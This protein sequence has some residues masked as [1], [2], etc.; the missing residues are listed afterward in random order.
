MD[1]NQDAGAPGAPTVRRA[2][3][4]LVAAAIIALGGWL[5][6]QERGFDRETARI[7]EVLELE[8][9]M[10]VADV[11]AGDG[12]FSIFLAE[13]VG[14]SGRVFSTEINDELVDGVREAVGG[15]DLD[16]VTVIL[17]ELDGTN[18]PDAC[19]DRILLRRVYH[20]FLEADPMDQ[21]MFA[22][23]EPGGLIAVIDF[24]PRDDIAQP[25]GTPAERGGHGTPIDQLIDE[26]T[27]N[28]FELDRQVDGWPGSERDYCVVFRKPVR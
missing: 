11:G 9:G 13:R 6:W 17:G 16:N 3:A 25:P 19:C 27:R 14:G 2:P 23:L 8:P 20:H 15:A 1:S 21:S 22:A 24:L 4:V 7:A 18:L 5:V 10:T 28:G 12:R 26:M